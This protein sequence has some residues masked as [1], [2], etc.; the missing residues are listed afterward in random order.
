MSAFVTTA[1]TTVLLLMML[2]F[3]NVNCCGQLSIEERRLNL[4]FEGFYLDLKGY[5]FIDPILVKTMRYVRY[6]G[7]KKYFM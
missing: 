4:R 1:T 7:P 5:F 6:L 3:Q 2:L